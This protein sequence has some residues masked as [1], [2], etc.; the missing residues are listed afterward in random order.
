M[1]ADLSVPGPSLPKQHRTLQAPPAASFHHPCLLPGVVTKHSLISRVFRKLPRDRKQQPWAG[2]CWGQERPGFCSPV[3]I[4][5]DPKTT[6]SVVL[7][8]ARNGNGPELYQ[9]TGDNLG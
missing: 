2:S 6:K 8:G 9:F 3:Q 5:L 4:I 1:F 7:T